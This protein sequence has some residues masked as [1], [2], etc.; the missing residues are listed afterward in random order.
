RATVISGTAE[1]VEDIAAQLA[2]RGHR[3]R[4]LKVS[5]AFHS[6]L[7]D[8]M[9][10]EFRQVLAGVEFHTPRLPMPAGDAALDPEYWV[11]HI[12]NTVRFTGQI[13][14]LEQ[15]D[16]TLYLEIGPG[17]VLTAMAQDTIT[18]AGAL[19][20]P[21]LHKNHDETHAITRT[22]A[23]LH[24][25]GTL[26]DWQAFFSREGSV[27]R[28]VELPTYA[29]QRRRYWLD[30][31]SGRR[32]RTAG[33]PVDGWRYRVVWR[34]MASN[35]ADLKGDWLL[36]V[37]AGHEARPLVRD[38]VRALE[39]GHGAVRQVV[40]GPVDADR[41]RFAE[42]LRGVLEEFDATGVLS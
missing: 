15:H 36:L 31:T 8:P 42:E 40:L 12:R 7:M 4:R 33:S 10:E 13:S 20:L 3:T 27:P 16:T 6:P 35:N 17:G 34:P 41:V 9:L 14:W 1:A 21:T 24:A 29:F 11:R 2:T 37:P 19:L 32:E 5:H 28:R 26:V 39:S 30:A 25:N 23:E 22:A 38:V 18:R